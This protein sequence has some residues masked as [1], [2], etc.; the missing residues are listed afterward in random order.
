MF[1]VFVK[2]LYRFLAAPGAHSWPTCIIGAQLSGQTISPESAPWR[3][4]W[5]QFF[6]LR[7]DY[8]FV[9]T[10]NININKFLNLFFFNKKEHFAV[11]VL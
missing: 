9:E 5:W 10:G 8:C 3:P 2:F 1:G 4:D 11:R 6:A 7:P